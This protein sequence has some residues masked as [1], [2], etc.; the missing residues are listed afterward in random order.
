MTPPPTTRYLDGVD[1]TPTWLSPT[2]PVVN[3]HR[4]TSTTGDGLRWTVTTLTPANP[5]P[6]SRT[7]CRRAP[8]CP[9]FG[10]DPAG[11]LAT[12]TDRYG[13]TTRIDRNADGSPTA[14]IA[15]F[16]QRTTL[17]VDPHG[18]LAAIADPVGDTTTMAST[19]SG[20]LTAYTD[21]NHHTS[22]LTY[23]G[24]GRLT[25]DDGPDGY[26]KTLTRTDTHPGYTVAVTTGLGRTTT[27]QAETLPDRSQRR[28]VTAPDGSH[29]TLVKT[30]DATATLTQADGTVITTR[31]GPDPAWGCA[32]RL[33]VAAPI[34]PAPV[35]AA[36]CFGCGVEEQRNS[37]QRPAVRTIL[38]IWSARCPGRR[39]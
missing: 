32:H 14:T 35:L 39:S 10:Y 34:R 26:T 29:T 13:N 21:P 28:T 27:Y 36:I 9:K 18:Y 17:T 5:R 16:G 37:G 24:Q 23:D 19:T 2:H 38:R 22:H 15:P 8:S 4:G 3:T 12:I 1:T 25:R 30:A 31:D 7:R 33:V 11:R 20:L 6:H